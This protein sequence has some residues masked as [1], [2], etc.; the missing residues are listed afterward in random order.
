MEFVLIPK[1]SSIIGSPDDSGDSRKDETPRHSILI[2]K[3]FYLGKYEVTQKQYK[4]VMGSN[5]SKFKLFGEI[6]PVE[7]G[8]KPKLRLLYECAPLA[9][10][11]E[12][13]GGSAKC[14]ESNILD[15]TIT[16]YHQTT[17]VCLGKTDL[18]KLWMQS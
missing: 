17:D 3:A 18:V 8:K 12:T 14:L 4:T 16:D 5:I 11:T 13:L 7:N 6:R 1:G 9:L 2:E 15:L 10:I